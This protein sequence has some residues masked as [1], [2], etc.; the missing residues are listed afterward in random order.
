MGHGSCQ[1]LVVFFQGLTLT[2]LLLPPL[3]VTFISTDPSANV[4]VLLDSQPFFQQAFAPLRSA[5]EIHD[6]DTTTRF[7]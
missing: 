6:S 4:G 2:H 1:S 5:I 3:V 7:C